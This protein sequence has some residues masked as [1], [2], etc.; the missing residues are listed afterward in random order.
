MP[1]AR[2]SGFFSYQYLSMPDNTLTTLSTSFV[3]Y[4]TL[5]M[6]HYQFVYIRSISNSHEIRIFFHQ[7]PIVKPI[8]NSML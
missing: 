6:I 3:L 4:P 5:L 1:D 7:C 8:I 2:A